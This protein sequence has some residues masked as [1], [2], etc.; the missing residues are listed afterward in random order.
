MAEILDASH[1]CPFSSIVCVASVEAV[2]VSQEV[3]GWYLLD[4]DWEEVVVGRRLWW[5][6]V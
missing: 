6:D 4:V 3:V 5:R 1:P 2:R